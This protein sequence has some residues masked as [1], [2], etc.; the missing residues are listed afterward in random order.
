MWSLIGNRNL[1][2]Q[3]T[4]LSR[5]LFIRGCPC[6]GVSLQVHIFKCQEFRIPPFAS[7]RF[8]E[9]K[10]PGPREYIDDNTSIRLAV[11][12]PTSVYRKTPFLCAL[13]CDVFALSETSA[14]WEVQRREGIALKHSGFA[15]V[16]GTPV[17]PQTTSMNGDSLR[18]SSIGVSIHSR[19]PLRPARLPK[20]DWGLSG[21][22]VHGFV[23]FR[24]LEIQIIALYGFPANLPQSK[25]RTDQL[26]QSAIEKMRYTTH[27][28]IICGDL[29]HHPQTLGSW[30]LLQ[31]MGFV[32]AEQIFNRQTLTELPPTYG[33]STRNDVAI[34]ST[35]LVPWIQKIE[36]DHQ[37]LFA[38]HNPLIVTMQVPQQPI[39]RTTW[40]LPKTWIEL[41][42]QTELIERHFAVTNE[43]DCPPNYE[44]PLEA[45]SKTVEQS[46]H[47]A[48]QEQH[49]ED[50]L[51]FPVLGL[52]RKYRG[53]C[54]KRGVVQ[55]PNPISVKQAWG[56]HYTPQTDHP[57]IHLKQLTKQIRRIQSL[58]HRVLKYE[59]QGN[60]MHQE[61]QLM[62]EWSKILAAAGFQ[63][64]F[65]CW[66]VQF[67]ELNPVPLE[68]PQSTYLYDLEQI[69][70]F[71][72]DDKVAFLNRQSREHSKFMM[73]LDQ[74]YGKKEA[75]RKV[76]EVG[77]G[78][79]TQIKTTF[80]TQAR[81]LHQPGDGTIQLKIDKLDAIDLE[82]SFQ[83]NGYVADPID[84]Q[85]PILE[86]MLHE[87]ERRFDP[88]VEITQER[89]SVDPMDFAKELNQYWSHFG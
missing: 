64:G 49:H 72:A 26:L 36:V 53:R 55:T 74:K 80:S 13:D 28:T 42:P 37:H 10:N 56:G 33:S 79:L 82:K 24:N 62:E 39:F 78:T 88:T 57:S 16:W 85:P 31:Q 40:R 52:S 6:L 59:R 46:V 34:F 81:V 18:G 23:K 61:D 27:P 14:T 22:L 5:L 41:G 54:K 20:S 75:F 25:S 43:N 60:F 69:L 17:P 9:A 47:L 32:T 67:V 87:A 68:V 7:V 19:Y 65:A 4:I 12:N 76:K 8:G 1:C 2:C 84:F 63:G 44:C 29:N 86:A 35:Q 51:K 66:M 70:R 45:W 48:L 38:G 58:K 3:L 77:P 11:T 50:P 21:R 73:Q 71:H 89:I 30:D 83:I 15:S